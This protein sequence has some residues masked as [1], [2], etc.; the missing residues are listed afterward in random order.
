M[1]PINVYLIS[2]VYFA[3]RGKIFCL[4]PHTIGHMTGSQR[5]TS[6]KRMTYLRDYDVCNHSV[7]HACTSVIMLVLASCWWL[8]VTVS[9]Y[10]SV[11]RS[12]G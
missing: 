1:L 5:M 8:L 9:G 10:F 7:Y 3:S 4:W 2:S 6:L 12:I 11:A